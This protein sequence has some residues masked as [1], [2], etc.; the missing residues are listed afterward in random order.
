MKRLPSPHVLAL[1]L[2]TA[3]IC[4][5]WWQV[6]EWF[7]PHRDAGFTLLVLDHLQDAW[8]SRGGWQDAPLG[9]PFPGGT[10]QADWIG[11]PALIG[12]L[13]RPFGVGPESTY[14]GLV[15]AGLLG[16]GLAAHCL[17][18]ALIGPGPHTVLAAILVGMG[19]IAMAHAHHL[20]LVHHW[21][22]LIGAL[23]LAAGLERGRHGWM[24]LGMFALGASAHFGLY[25]GLQSL[26][27][28]LAVLLAWG[29]QWIRS[30]RAVGA[31][32]TGG[33][34]A[35]VT[36]L[37][38]VLLHAGIQS[39]QA[40]EIL[41]GD[42]AAESWDP[43]AIFG[44]N[45]TAPLHEWL[46]TLLG[47]P[48]SPRPEDPAN[49]GWAVLLLAPLGVTRALRSPQRR[50]W[51][52]VMLATGAGAAL[53]MGPTPVVGG[54]ELG[55]PGPHRLLEALTAGTARAPSRWLWLVHSGLG[56]FAAFGLAWI[57]NHL[58]AAA[59]LPV[60]VAVLLTAT[61]ELPRAQP[62]ARN[63]LPVPKIYQHLVDSPVPGPVYEVL[64]RGSV[65]AKA[66][67]L[68]AALRHGRPIVGGFY[69]R[70]SKAREALQHVLAGWPEPSAVEVLVALEVPF[71]LEYPP[72]GRPPPPDL[73]CVVE[74][75]YRLCRL[76]DRSQAVP[77][78]TA[79]APTSEGAVHALRWSEV[80]P[81]RMVEVQCSTRPTERYDVGAWL[82]LTRLR[83]GTKDAPLEIVLESPCPSIPQVADGQPTPLSPAEDA[84]SCEWLPALPS[85]R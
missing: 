18:R 41:T 20:N 29:P 66:T 14:L 27:L 15:L 2:L 9:W 37:P 33:T 34:A 46:A 60:L 10:A 77:C 7:F 3:W 52:A 67:R 32:A 62:M 24:A 45:P 65:E 50:G 16:S 85:W 28:G 74:D 35:L 38:V 25:M 76:P 49:P 26:V 8:I 21:P 59:R 40:P 11:G 68:R 81:A 70:Y 51:L 84:A 82:L 57:G 1:I 30:P 53:A 23:L 73:D 43:I 78:S 61:G 31:M 36:C 64:T 39:T 13:G 6:D 4:W 71:V 44:A 83:H 80:P 17:A 42:L 75:G 55:L 56:L 72:L 79:L 12:L 69:G 22:G 63:E 19:P 48:L 54:F 47:H 58:P 5:P